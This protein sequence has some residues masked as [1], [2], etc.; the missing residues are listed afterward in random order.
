M[1]VL[2]IVFV[3]FSKHDVNFTVQIIDIGFCH[4]HFLIKNSGLAARLLKSI[5]IHPHGVRYGTL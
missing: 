3:M 2:E 1:F 5:H 4:L